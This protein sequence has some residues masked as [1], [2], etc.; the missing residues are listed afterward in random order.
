MTFP[1]IN[2]LNLCLYVFFVVIISLKTEID[3]INMKRLEDE[4]VRCNEIKVENAKLLADIAAK[5]E[6]LQLLQFKLIQIQEKCQTLESAN[7]KLEDEKS[8]L[9]EQL[10][11]LLQQNQELLT[12]AL[13]SKDSYHEQTKSYM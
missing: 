9:F 13:N 11:L 4:I 7:E 6:N 1:Q 10:H 12:Q 2:N 3:E 5:K 8:Q